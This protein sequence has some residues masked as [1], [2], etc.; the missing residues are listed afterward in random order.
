[1]NLSGFTSQPK[2]SPPPTKSLLVLNARQVSAL[3]VMVLTVLPAVTVVTVTTTAVV[4]PRTRVPVLNSVHD[5]VVSA[6]V[7]PSQCKGGSWL[8]GVVV[9]ILHYYYPISRFPSLCVHHH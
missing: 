9:R 2:L 8:R 7:R 4:S 3:V 5:S 6:V 1:M